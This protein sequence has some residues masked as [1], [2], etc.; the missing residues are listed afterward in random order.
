M[1]DKNKHL[2]IRFFDRESVSTV[3]L[4]SAHLLQEIEWRTFPSIK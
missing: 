4:V 2:S 1:V 3:F